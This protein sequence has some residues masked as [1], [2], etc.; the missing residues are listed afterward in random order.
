MS[1]K[2]PIKRRIVIA[3]FLMT[4]VVGGT[5]SIS[6]FIIIQMLEEHF[7]SQEL[8]DNLQDILDSHMDY[9][10][11]TKL[12][13][14]SKFYTSNTLVNFPIPE[15][16]QNVKEGFSEILL[17]NGNSYYAY[18]RSID[19]HVYLVIKDQ[20]EF[21][22]REQML[23]LVV[24]IGF[25]SSLI[26]AWILGNLLANR[27]L[28]PVIRLADQVDDID[29]LQSIAGKK[30]LYSQYADDEVGQLA[31]AFDRAFGELNSSLARERLFTS[32]VSHELRTPLMV[33]ASSCE[34]L[35]ESN[36]VSADSYRKIERISAANKD[37]YDLVETFLMLARASNEQIIG[38]Q[39]TL[40]EVVKEQAESWHSKFIDKKITFELET[41]GGS[42]R[43]YNKV[44]LK[45]VVSNLL[46]NALHYTERGRVK[47]ITDK[48]SFAVIDTGVGVP[49]D[50]QQAIFQAFVRGNTSRGEGLGLGLSLVKRICLHQGWQVRMVSN[51]AGGSIFEVSLAS[52]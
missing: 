30:T 31:D 11:V 12:G 36:T 49:E 2:Q 8:D 7:V 22:H 15:D 6:I 26:I 41:R 3:F 35:L 43:H 52:S 27:I 46:R 25:I 21:E 32:D 34:L 4:L 38:E 42:S 20:S 44:L 39:V 13:K 19:N 5:S 17:R 33:I 47:L 28:A 37:M 50:Q 10:E 48:H 1:L 16:F 40:Q 51:P 24:S 14:H 23:I 18:R 29:Y 45:T 9:E